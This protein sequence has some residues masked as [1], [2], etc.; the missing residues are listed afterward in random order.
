MCP[1]GNYRERSRNRKLA[2][3]HE[4]NKFHLWSNILSENQVIFGSHEVST[5]AR[6]VTFYANYRNIEYLTERFLDATLHAN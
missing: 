3:G 5:D 1:E 4:A 2:R 6:A